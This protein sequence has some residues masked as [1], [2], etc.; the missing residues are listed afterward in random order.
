MCLRTV[1]I[2]HIKDEHEAIKVKL[3]NIQRDV[4]VSSKVKDRLIDVETQN[5]SNNLVFFAIDEKPVIMDT[6]SANAGNEGVDNEENKETQKVE[7]CI[8]VVLDFCVNTLNIEHARE[9]IKIEKAY[10]LGKRTDDAVRPRPIVVKFS[11]YSDREKIRKSSGRLK[12]TNY[13]ISPQYPPEVLANRKKLI[14]VMI[15]KR[16]E[17]KSAYLVGDKLYVE[18]VLWMALLIIHRKIKEVRNIL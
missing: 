11:Q 1:P 12:G 8:E 2:F 14:P 17:K 3:K 9:N 18:G 4:D 13:G 10:R 5:L 7:N 6:E 16:K 15:K